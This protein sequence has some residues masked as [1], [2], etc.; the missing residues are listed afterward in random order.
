MA[1][2]VVPD[3]ELDLEARARGTNLY[4]PE[5]IIHMLPT[6]ITAKLGLGLQ[7]Q[8]PALSI[9]FRLSPDGEPVDITITPSWIKASRESYGDID[10]RIEQEPFATM[11]QMARR[12]QQRREE[13]GA[14]D[15]DLPEVSV[16]V[17]EGR[18][19]ITPQERSASR[20]MVAA[21]MILAGEATARYA[22][23]HD[24]RRETAQALLS[25]ARA[26]AVAATSEERI[27]ELETALAEDGEPAN[28]S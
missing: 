12:S 10:Q 6:A 3:S 26:D 9:G 22:L 19:V 27:R 25:R 20:Q 11:L 24:K 1:A 4:L 15:I 18:V 7:E 23:E 2:L 5:R 16:R 14:S 13:A 8:S 17:I 21:A 28:G